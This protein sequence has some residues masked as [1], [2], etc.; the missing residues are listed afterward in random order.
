MAAARSRK[1]QSTAP[2]TVAP[3]GSPGATG[4]GARVLVTLALC[5]MVVTY[6]AAQVDFLRRHQPGITPERYWWPQLT[7]ILL[8]GLGTAVVLAFGGWLLARRRS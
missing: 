1:P 4:R 3:T 8:P 6:V 2:T 5:A 7:H